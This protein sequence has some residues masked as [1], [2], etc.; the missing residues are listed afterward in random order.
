MHS[1]HEADG[2]RAKG[3]DGVLM[4]KSFPSILLDGSGTFNE[5]IRHFILRF[6]YFLAVSLELPI[7]H[8]LKEIEQIALQVA[9]RV[10]SF[11]I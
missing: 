4:L 11:A 9:A 3:A 10:E 8:I 1:L 6:L 5:K 2:W 7:F